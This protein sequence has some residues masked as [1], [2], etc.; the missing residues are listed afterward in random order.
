MFRAYDSSKIFVKYSEYVVKN[1]VE[2]I[3]L[4]FNCV[5]RQEE[6]KLV[7]LSPDK[8]SLIEEKF[9]FVF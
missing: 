2:T 8:K 5:I 6:K 3:I 4:S 7:Q 1:T 9:T